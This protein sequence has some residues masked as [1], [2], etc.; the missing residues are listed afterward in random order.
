MHTMRFLQRL[1]RVSRGMKKG[2]Q[3]ISLVAHK[4]A[5]KLAL[6]QQR[7]EILKNINEILNADKI[8]ENEIGDGLYSIRVQKL[9]HN[10]CI[11]ILRKDLER[12]L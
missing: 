2:E 11:D 1:L 8:P 6:D 9:A 12:W 10:A 7:H 3:I 4:E 5:L